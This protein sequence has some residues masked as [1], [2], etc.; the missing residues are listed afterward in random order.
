LN[1][2]FKIDNAF[3]CVTGL[4]Y[5]RITEYQNYWL[6]KLLVMKIPGYGIWNY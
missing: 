5:I 2:R 4:K 3:I 1:K 6:P